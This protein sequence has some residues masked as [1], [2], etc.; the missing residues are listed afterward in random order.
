[1]VRVAWR[2]SGGSAWAGLAAVPATVT[3]LSA[4]TASLSLAVMVSVPALVVALAAMV[5][6]LPDML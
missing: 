4:A 3:V 5:R 1:M 2:S 6:V